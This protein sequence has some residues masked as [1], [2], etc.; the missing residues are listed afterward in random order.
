MAEQEKDKTEKLPYRTTKEKF[1]KAI[2]AIRQ[3]PGSLDALDFAVGKVDRPFVVR[4]LAAL[5]LV[6]DP[7][8]PDLTE[9]G[10]A[11]A[12]AEGHERNRAVLRALLGFPPYKAVLQEAASRK[13][14]SI[15]VKDIVS[16]WGQK[17]FGSDDDARLGGAV[18]LAGLMASAGLGDYSVGRRGSPSRVTLST[19]WQDRLV[20]AF[21]NAIQPPL[22]P[23]METP[24]ITPKLPGQPRQEEEPPKLGFIRHNFQLRRGMVIQIELPDDLTLKEVERLS[25]WMATLPLQEEKT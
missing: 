5:G 2:Q 4:T 17:N 25:T 8:K 14:E 13:L 20:G 1:T 15:G 7:Q 22:Q 16:T 19:G 3:S 10:R 11:I 12:Y 18:V 6:T 24:P 21:S 23:G 9:A